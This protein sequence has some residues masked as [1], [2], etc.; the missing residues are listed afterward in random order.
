[1]RV[2]V[3]NPA[4]VIGPE[5]YAG[6]EFGTLCERFW[7]GKIPIHFGGG[8]NFVDV[9][10]ASKE[11]SLWPL[12][13]NDTP[14]F[15]EREKRYLRKNGEP[16]WAR[17]LRVPIRDAALEARFNEL[18]WNAMSQTTRMEIAEASYLAQRGRPMPADFLYR[19][20]P[21]MEALARLADAGIPLGNQSVL[22]RNVNDDVEVMKAHVQKLPMCR[23]KPYYLYQ[24]DLIS[25]SAH[26]RSSVRKGLEIMEKLRG[27]TTGYAVP[28]YVIDAPDGGGHRVP[29]AEQPRSR[30][31]RAGGP[32]AG[33]RRLRALRRE[34]A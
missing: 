7:R 15:Y 4:S 10:D 33:G 8:N 25:G 31:R 3:V 14:S 32:A 17:V 26:L 34:R 18:Y 28:Q 30:R 11:G 12:A 22:L 5:D 29:E 2:V 23:V 1:M 16:I 20:L 9:R 24:C 21:V 6:S 27:H 19:M 13:P